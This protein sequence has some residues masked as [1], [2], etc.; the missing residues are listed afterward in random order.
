MPPMTSRIVPQSDSEFKQQQGS[1]SFQRTAL[2]TQRLPVLLVLSWIVLYAFRPF[3][4]GFYHDDW[5][6]FVEPVHATAAFSWARLHWFIGSESAFNPRPLLGV[7]AFF[8]SSIFGASAFGFQ[9]VSSLLV[10]LAA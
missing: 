2:L 8:V 6:C 1:D 10:L 7:V 9:C 3:Q 4:L 5:P